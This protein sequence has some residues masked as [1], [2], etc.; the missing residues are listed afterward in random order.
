MA[1]FFK[2]PTLRNEQVL[3]LKYTGRE[4]FEASLEFFRSLPMEERLYLRRNVTKRE[5]VEERIGE[6]ERGLATGIVAVAGERIVGDALLFVMPHGCS[7]RTGEVRLLVHPD[8][9]GLGLGTILARELFI[10]AVRK[11][12]KKLE[13]CVMETQ[14]GAKRMLE[15]L[16]FVQE[17][18]LEGFVNDLKGR[19]HN[20]ILM[21]MKL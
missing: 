21:G 8:Y 10:L 7:R 15:R 2:E 16:G 19:E 5:I 20:L 9:R 11:D 12:L 6:I 14:V 13:S 1:G 3:G 18:I 17:G 4:D